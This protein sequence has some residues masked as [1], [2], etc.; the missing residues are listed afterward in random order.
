MNKC[1][2]GRGFVMAKYFHLIIILTAA[3]LTAASCSTPERNQKKGDVLFSRGEY[4]EAALRYKTAYSMTPRKDREGRGMRAFLMGECYRHINSVAKAEGAYRNAARYDY[5]D[6]TTLFH[7]AAMQRML[8]NYKAAADNYRLYLEKHPDDPLS[9][10]GLASCDLAKQMKEEGSSYIVKSVPLLMSRRADYCPV[11]YGEKWDKLLFTS[12]RTE[13]MGDD[14]SPITGMKNGDFFYTQKDEKGKWKPVE[15]LQGNVN[16]AYDEGA[17]CITPDGGTMYFTYCPTDPE[18]P[19]YAEIWSSS[20]SDATWSKPEKVTIS[21]DTLSSYAHPAVSPDG[22]W[23]YFVSDMPGGLGG[24]DIWRARLNGNSIGA[25]ENLGAPV[26]SSGNEMFPTFRPDGELYFSSDG[27][28]GMGGLDIY[29]ARE[30]TVTGKWTVE[31]LPSPVNSSGDDFSM[32]FEGVH[33]RGYFSSNRKNGRG[34]DHIYSFEKPEVVH[35]VFGYVYEQDGYELPQASVYMV[36]ND[37]TNINFGVRADGSFEQEIKPGVKYVLLATCD[38][39]LNYKQDFYIDS[40]DVS[41]TD[42]LYFPLPSVNSPVLVRNVFYEFNSAKLTDNSRQALDNLTRLLKDNPNTSIELSSH[43]DYRGNE[44]YNRRLSQH[45]AESVVDYLI[46][47][48]IEP[49]RLTAVGYGKL[50]P[51]VVTRRLA[52]VYKFLHEGD[53]LTEKY[54]K[55]LKAAWQDTC[56]ALN[57]R[58][59]FK[60]LQTTYGLTDKAGHLDAKALLGVRKPAAAKEPIVKVYVPTPAEAAAADGKPLPKAGDAKGKAVAAGKGTV[61]NVKE[62]AA[63]GKASAGKGT[64]A[65]KETAA[66]VKGTA[67]NGKAAAA[68]KNTKTAPA[69]KTDSTAKAVNAKKDSAAKV[70]AASK[71]ATSTA[72]SKTATADGKATNAAG[73]TA[74][75]ATVA[76]AATGKTDTL[77]ANAKAKV[78]N[79]KATEKDTKAAATDNKAAATDAKATTNAA[80]AA[81]TDAKKATTDTKAAKTDT[82]A[83][84]T[85]KTSAVTKT[86]PTAT[87]TKNAATDAKTA[88]KDAKDTK[89]D[90]ASTG[91]SAVKNSV[92]ARRDSLLRARKEAADAAKKSAAAETEKTAAKTT[93]NTAKAAKAAAKTAAAT[94]TATTATKAAATTAAAT[95][96]KTATKAAKAA[97][98]SAKAAA[99]T[100][101]AAKTTAKSATTTTKSATTAADAASAKARA[102]AAAKAEKAA[103]KAR[104]KAAAKARRDSIATAKAAAKAA[105]AKAKAEKKAAKLKADSIKRAEKAAAK[106]RA[107]SVKKAQKAAAKQQT[108]ARAQAARSQDSAKVKS[109]VRKKATDTTAATAKAAKQTAKTAASTKTAAKST[110]KSATTTTK[111]ATK[112]A[113]AAT[114]ATKAAATAAKATS[115]TT[116]TATSAA[117]STSTSAKAATTT[118][119]TNTSTSKATPKIM[120]KALQDS[121]IAKARR[122]AELE[123]AKKN[124]K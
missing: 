23:L 114:S 112:T 78:T 34:W 35:S 21:A 48:G 79:T 71:A 17:A 59:E 54:I 61:V 86:T 47:H 102:K 97:A 100:A 68:T 40:S 38:S 74:T 89:T 107:D 109:T 94:K 37:G 93:T 14:D 31:I 51:K 32:T 24:Y 20:R 98:T 16:T 95:T 8:G 62:A 7:L 57:R 77:A 87:D 46:A 67:A 43:C 9:I 124:K 103:A 6:T 64:A 42:T 1:A 19:R 18:Y 85:A 55:R 113:K 119:K 92:R 12:T 4:Y 120:D 36:G 76:K 63:A 115:T 60:V 11:L 5:T 75:A 15:A 91:K 88:A 10:A 72:A 82:N 44:L 26:N 83:A 13:A 81:K 30:D 116:K 123:K 56:N 49:G 45:R 96:A 70:S 25:M 99:N 105:A 104:K 33:N 28:P 3:V 2:F 41:T 90:K 27:H 80:T 73:K 39:F 58:T 69:A 22:R 52:S 53:T 121:I 50:R 110:A 29:R 122:D 106:Q 117:K 65:G 111:T 118:T 84:A 66:N 108:V 101:K